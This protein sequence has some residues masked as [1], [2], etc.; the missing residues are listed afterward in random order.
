VVLSDGCNNAADVAAPETLARQLGSRGV[1]IY[2][3]GVGPETPTRNMAALNIKDLAVA[4]EVQAFNQMGINATLDC[5]G[6]ANRQVKVICTLGAAEVAS[7]TLAVPNAQSRLP[8]RLSHVPTAAGFQRLQ[9]KAQVVGPAVANLTGEQTVSKLV[10]VIDREM[11]ILYVEGKFRGE[12]KFIAQALAAGGRFAV[13]RVVVTQPLSQRPMPGVGG[14]LEEWL[15]YHAII[16]GDAQLQMIRKVIGE[17]GKGFCM[18]GGRDSF[19]A[20]GWNNTPLADLMPV[21]LAASKGQIDGDVKVVPTREG[22]AS[23]LLRLGEGRPEQTA[24]AWAE[25]PPLLGANRLAGVKLAAQTLAESAKGEP[26]IVAQQY[27]KGRSLAIAFDTTWRWVLNPKDTAE[28]QRRFWRQVALYLCAPKGNVWIAT[29]K[30]TYDSRRLAGGQDVIKVTAGV[31]DAQG[32]PINDPKVTVTL[33]YPDKKTQAIFLQRQGAMLAATLPP[34]VS[35]PGIYT[36]TITAPEVKPQPS[37]QQFEVTRRDLEAMDVLANHELLRQMSTES[38]GKYAPLR[39]LGALLDDI[40]IAARPRP[41]EEVIHQDLTGDFRWWVLG[42]IIALL[43][44]EWAIRK[45]KGLV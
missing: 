35:E 29:D 13:N 7:E 38:R 31:E 21:D 26:L 36:L 45:R 9:I 17:Y 1:P 44:L 8:L 37:E 32:R 15:S 16:F 5:I 20:G 41:R 34:N 3:V 42:A 19:G 24:A 2:T 12:S 11:R 10:H 33:V 4:D 22:L 25:L 40:A 39:D 43:C 30:S 6:L 18:I 27:E 14:N 23:D 28:S